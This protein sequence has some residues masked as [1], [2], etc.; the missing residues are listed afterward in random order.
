MDR[1]TLKERQINDRQ[2]EGEE[3]SVANRKKECSDEQ[4]IN[5][6]MNGK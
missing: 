3:D 1:Q 4:G 6:Q 2:M 5:R